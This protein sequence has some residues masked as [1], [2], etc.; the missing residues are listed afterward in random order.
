[1]SI[2]VHLRYD[3][4]WK[5]NKTGPRGRGGSNNIFGHQGMLCN[6]KTTAFHNFKGGSGP[7]MWKFTFF[8]IIISNEPFP[9]V[10][11][12]IVSRVQCPMT[13]L[14]L[15]NFFLSEHPQLE[16]DSKAALVDFIYATLN[17]H[18]KKGVFC[19]VKVYLWSLSSLIRDIRF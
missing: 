1:M 7:K 11:W 13:N 19:A 12:P 4:E 9:Y 10:Q 3:L 8:F 17:L 5:H 2:H 16:L 6:E 15:N 18:L 14:F